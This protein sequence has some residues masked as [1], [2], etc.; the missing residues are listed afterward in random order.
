MEEVEASDCVVKRVFLLG[1][2][3][4]L[5]VEQLQVGVQ[6]SFAFF[7][8]V[9]PGVFFTADHV[10]AAHLLTHHVHAGALCFLLRLMQVGMRNA[11]LL[12]HLPFLTLAHGCSLS[13][14]VE[15]LVGR[16]L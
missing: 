13:L 3:L 8:A 12:Q 16:R 1:D 5:V 9:E 15:R 4:L 10:I 6:D 7:L 2:G 14:N 11:L